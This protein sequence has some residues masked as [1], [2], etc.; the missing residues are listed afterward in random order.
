MESER[1]SSPAASNSSENPADSSSA[2][3]PE[4]IHTQHQANPA[5]EVITAGFFSPTYGSAESD[6][7]QPEGESA[8][9]PVPSSDDEPPPPNK[10]Q[11]FTTVGPYEGDFMDSDL[12]TE[13]PPVADAPTKRTHPGDHPGP[14]KKKARVTVET[15]KLPNQE[16]LTVSDRTVKVFEKQVHWEDQQGFYSQL[17]HTK[18]ASRTTDGINNGEISSQDSAVDP[19]AGA[20]STGPTQV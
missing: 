18:R 14:A 15:A 10:Q 3:D 17:A 4:H 5:E 8:E 12:D 6:D 16:E 9:E 20:C 1:D 2:P 11:T 19:T 7:G 13:P